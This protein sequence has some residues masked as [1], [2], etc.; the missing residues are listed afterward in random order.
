MHV[1]REC[2]AANRAWARAMRERSPGFF[3]S[4]RDQQH[5]DLLWIGCSDSRLTPT[6]MIGRRPGDLFVHRNVANLVTPGDPSAL[7]VIEYALVTLGV[8]HVLVVGHYGCGGVR[9]VLRGRPRGHVGAWL[10]PLRALAARHR[11]VL[12]ALPAPEREDRLCELNVAAQVANVCAAPA[13]RAAH[14]PVWVH[15][16]IY[17]VADGLLRDLGLSIEGGAAAGARHRSW[18]DDDA[19]EGAPRPTP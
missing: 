12:D 18:E 7:A 19:E 1:L 3:E 11:H 16:W 15:G 9:A 8:R 5:P 17:S 14:M 4:L 6:H 13:V 2:L 10:R